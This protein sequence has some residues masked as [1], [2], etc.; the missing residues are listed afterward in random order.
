[1]A[2]RGD[3]MKDITEFL[4][5]IGRAGGYYYGATNGINHGWTGKKGDKNGDKKLNVKEAYLY[6]KPLVTRSTVQFWSSESGLIL[7]P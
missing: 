5:G 2:N 6:A 7:F 4:R 3:E 1:M